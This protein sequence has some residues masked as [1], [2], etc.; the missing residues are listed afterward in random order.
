[1]QLFSQLTINDPSPQLA[2]MFAAVRA[3]L[4]RLPFFTIVPAYRQVGKTTIAQ[5]EKLYIPLNKKLCRIR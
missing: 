4:H 5:Q 1:M 2:R 3:Q